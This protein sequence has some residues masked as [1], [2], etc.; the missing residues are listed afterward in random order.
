MD[1]FQIRDDYVLV[2]TDGACPGN[3]IDPDARA[4]LGVWWNKG[5]KWLV[6]CVVS[7]DIIIDLCLLIC[8]LV[9]IFF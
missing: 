8:F 4:G 3:G 2:W 7:I 1:G 6:L 5:H 9:Y